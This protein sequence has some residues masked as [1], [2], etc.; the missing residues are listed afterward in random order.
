MFLFLSDNK[1][2]HL[3][4]PSME[5][6]SRIRTV[7]AADFDNDGELEI[8]FNNIPGINKLF[9]WNN[10]IAFWDLLDIGDALEPAGMLSSRLC[11][12]VLCS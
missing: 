9:K 11:F 10:E 3:A 6:P 7:I 5:Q 1:I 2:Q 12:S 4:H 8:F